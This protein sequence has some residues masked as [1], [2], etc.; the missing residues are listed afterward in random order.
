V[1]RA[2]V[3]LPEG[4]LDKPIGEYDAKTL[5]WILTGHLARRAGTGVALWLLA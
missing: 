4:G 1:G 2:Y 5:A 3:I